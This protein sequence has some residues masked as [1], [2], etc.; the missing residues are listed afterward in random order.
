MAT[1]LNQQAEQYETVLD[2]SLLKRSLD[3][4]TSAEREMRAAVERANQAAALC[5][6][7]IITLPSLSTF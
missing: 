4:V 6:K 5:N 3:D 1:M 2:T 7:P